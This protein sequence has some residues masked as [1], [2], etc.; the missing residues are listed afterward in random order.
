MPHRHAQLPSS[1]S[2]TA[3][4]SLTT[5]PGSHSCTVPHA[6][7]RYITACNS[8]Y[9]HFSLATPAANYSHCSP[10]LPRALCSPRLITTTDPAGHTPCI[11][12]ILPL[13]AERTN[14]YT[15]IGPFM[16][17]IGSC[18]VCKTLIFFKNKED[19][20]KFEADP[21]CSEECVFLSFEHLP[22]TDSTPDNR[23]KH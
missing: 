23:P 19:H 4:V 11:A 14:N 20:S 10:I 3:A 12:V 13:M 6:T 22:C 21:L 5:T 15:G 2:G 1:P 7:D 8:L 18:A 17:H 9:S 16:K